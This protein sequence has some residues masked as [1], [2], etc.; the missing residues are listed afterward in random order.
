L[1]SPREFTL[2]PWIEVRK[3]RRDYSSFAS[4][5]LRLAITPAGLVGNSDIRP[6]E[7]VSRNAIRRITGRIVRSHDVFFLEEEGSIRTYILT[8]A[9]QLRAYEGKK[10]R[11]LGALESPCVIAVQAIHELD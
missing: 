1:L 2:N 10:V 3:M 5:L 11:I 4:V 6:Q 8:G 7:K 9:S